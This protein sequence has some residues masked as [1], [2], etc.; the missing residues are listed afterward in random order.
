MSIHIGAGPIGWY[1]DD[2]TPFG[3]DIAR[4]A[5]LITLARAGFEGLE[6]GPRSRRDVTCV[7]AALLRHGL[8]FLPNTHAIELLGSSAEAEFARLGDHIAAAKALGAGVVSVAETTGAVHANRA[9]PLTKRPKIDVRQW[10]DFGAKLSA[11]AG[12]VKSAGLKLAYRPHM[13]TVVESGNDVERLI[14]ATTADVGLLLDTGH[15]AWGGAKPKALAK[16]HAD[17]IV[18]IH[19]TDI[20]GERASAAIGQ[21]QSYLE[22]VDHGVFV[23]PGTGSAEVREVIAAL[24]DF[25]GWIVIDAERG[26]PAEIADLCR[27]SAGKQAA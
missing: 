3:N 7:R 15:L 18:M 14:A 16:A 1:E 12:L 9:M 5:H 6:L 26:L 27:P 19:L 23:A 22:A 4:E 10:I 2:F 21:R 24:P 20:D 11:L 25:D 8:A 13:G 17:R